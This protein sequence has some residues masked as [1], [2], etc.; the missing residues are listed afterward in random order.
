MAYYVIPDAEPK[1][2]DE[3]VSNEPRHPSDNAAMRGHPSGDEQCENCL[4]YL[5]NT[6]DISYCWHP[7]VR[8]LVGATWGCQWWEAIPDGADLNRDPRVRPPAV[9]GCDFTR[10]DFLR[11]TGV[12]AASPFFARR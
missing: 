9:P 10:R 5:E 3:N 6:A 1:E 8:I 2:S 4:Y 7:K 11:W 12:A